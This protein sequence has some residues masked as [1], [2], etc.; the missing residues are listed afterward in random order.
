MEERRAVM[1]SARRCS[2]AESTCRGNP[3]TRPAQP[4]FGVSSLRSQRELVGW[5]GFA[6]WQARKGVPTTSVGGVLTELTARV[7][8]EGETV[9]ETGEGV[10][11]EQSRTHGNRVTACGGAGEMSHRR[12]HVERS[13]L[14]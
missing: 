1:R 12:L 10:V 4:R 2:R 6:R 9:R 7:S 8:S 5:R 14:G 3:M 11:F 13:A